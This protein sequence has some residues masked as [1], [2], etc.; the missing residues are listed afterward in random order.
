MIKLKH[1][2]S[3]AIALSLLSCASNKS[4][5]DKQLADRIS[6]DDRL[7][8][9]E[10]MAEDLVSTGLTAGD[11]YGEVWIRDLNSFIELATKVNGKKATSDAL[12][13][14]FN[15]QG[16]DGNIPD[17]Y[18]PKDKA[19]IGYKYQNSELAPTLLAHKNTVETDQESS[20]I[21]AIS[22][23]VKY[24][25]ERELLDRVVDGKTVMNRMHDALQYLLDHRY[26]KQ[27]GLLW[28]A[29]TVDWGD[30]QPEH[31]WGVE[32][33]S[34]SHPAIDIY[35]NAMFVIAINDYLSLLD[36]SDKTAYWTTIKEDIT[37]NTKKHLWD[38]Q[39]KKYKPHVYLDKGSPFPASLDEDAIYY[40][41]GTFTA[42]EA[43]FL[44]KEEIKEAY[45]TMQE[46]VKKSG[47]PSIGLTVYP[48]YPNGT[49]L[50]KGL[51]EYS[52]QNGGDWTWFGAR[53]VQQ[54]IKNEMYQEAY[55]S[56]EPM[57]DLVLKHN[58]FYE[59]WKIDGEPAGSGMFRGAA[60]VL[61]K[62]VKMFEQ[63]IKDDKK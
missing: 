59:W 20:L 50:N 21:Q 22:R 58:G 63:Q 12:V 31:P 13:M 8:K 11:G 10:K 45:A 52:Y 9:I 35:D 2:L 55:E 49:F 19:N 5:I 47:A 4:T 53:M 28:G 62:S 44:T 24:T 43:G 42:I 51:G 3:C 57:M 6:K 17:G 14:F 26:N 36:E 15:F 48:P 30:V 29:T 1:A 33:D 56:L 38:V 16:K 23:Y 7:Q 27:Y 39:R 60:G 41:G 25:G 61:W 32:L 54:L 46:N 37:K 40:H 34:S 18:I